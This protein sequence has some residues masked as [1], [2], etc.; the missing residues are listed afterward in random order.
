MKKSLLAILCLVWVISI[1]AQVAINTDA[2]LAHNSAMLDIK[3]NNK[4]FLPPRMTWTQI[5]AIQNPAEGLLVYDTGLKAI[6]MFNGTSWVV[7]GI[8]TASLTDPPGYFSNF[9]G[10]STS[11]S[12]RALRVKVG[13]DKNVYVSGVVDQTLIFGTDTLT[14]SNNMFFAVFDS[15]GNYIFSKKFGG[16]TSEQ[17]VDMAVNETAIYIGGYFSGTTDLDPGPGTDNHTAANTSPFFV[18]FDLAGNIVWGKHLTVTS[19]SQ[20][21]Q[22]ILDPAGLVYISGDMSGTLDADPGAGTTNLVSAGNFDVFFAKYNTSGNLVWARRLGAGAADITNGL[23]MLN[24]SLVFAGLF[25]GL[26]DFDPSGAAFNLT[27]AGVTDYFLTRFD[28]SG[29]LLWAKQYGSAGT[30]SF[31][32][33]KI[34]LDISGNI[35]LAGLFTGTIDIN[36]DAGTQNVTSNGGVDFYVA[37][38]SGAGAL[39]PGAFSIGGTID[40]IVSDIRVDESDNIY[41]VGMFGGAVDFDPSFI[42]QN[43]VSSGSTDIF[44]A[45]Y[46][47]SAAIIFAKNMGGVIFDG[48]GGVAPFP[49]GKIIFVAGGS[50]APYLTFNGDRVSTGGFFLARYEE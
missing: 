49:G 42:A 16:G 7:L 35:C 4:G 6:R 3:S 24:G 36:P 37:K 18:K 21:K 1:S 38:Y 25:S 34:T 8:K 11:Q 39:L 19:T 41:I 44:L 31:T 50:T 30:E 17:I 48:L 27:S 12:S 5:Q 14:G 29:N 10:K 28:T 40:D 22:L 45:K 20:V 2:S 26:V 46:S 47:P 13:P 33:Q 15:L 43:L 23:V 9:S 32:G